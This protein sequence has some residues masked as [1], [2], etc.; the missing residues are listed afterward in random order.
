MKKLFTILI[1]FSIYSTIKIPFIDRDIEWNFD[2]NAIISKLKS[3]IPKYIEEIQN[4]LKKFK[5]YAEEK[6]DEIIKTVSEEAKAQYEQM[7]EDP[8][9]YFKPYAEKATAAANYLQQKVCDAIDST[10]Y[11]ECRESKRAMFSQIYGYVKDNFQ[12]SQI[13]NIIT[14]IDKDNVDQNLKYVLFL[15]SALTGNPDSIAKGEAQVMYDAMNCLQEKFKDYWPQIEAQL[16]D[17]TKRI[18]LK[19]DITDLMIQSYSN[20]INMIHF[21][22]IDGYIQKASDKTGLISDENAKKIHQ[23]LFKAL[24]KLNDFGNQMYNYTSNLA[25]EVFVN[26][27]NL[28]VGGD[29]ELV[30][31]DLEEKGIRIAVH[32]NYMLREFNAHALQYVVFDSPLVSVR[33]SRETDEG[34]ANTFV[35]ITLYDKEGNEVL[36]KDINV[37]DFKPIIYY[38][39]KLFNA[40]KTCLFYNEENDKLE[41]S[42]VETSTEII[43]GEEFIKCIPQHLTSF[44]I[45]SYEEANV[46]PSSSNA[47]TIVL[48]IFLILI[49]LALLVG[50][51][52]FYRKKYNNVDNSQL[53]Q[54]FVNKN[55]LTV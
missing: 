7:K 21:E 25:L 8:I 1:L 20:L 52:I 3:G 19:Q 23:G 12:C 37:K 35:G 44:T 22:E 30:I 2:F 34:T 32:A 26:P 39:K 11:N 28:E 15:M 16:T 55:G 53:E 17:E 9:A 6:K 43:N 18:Q 45:G 42:G 13:V 49:A 14:N 27:G 5:E 29:A 10:A 47:G 51:Y 38:K 24:S 4:E 48:V 50:G 46:S 36:V 41:S 40:M 31:K 54:A 33:G